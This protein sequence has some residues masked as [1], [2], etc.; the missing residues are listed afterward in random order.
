MIAI[1]NFGNPQ[2]AWTNKAIQCT[3]IIKN[4]TC[5]VQKNKTKMSLRLRR[6]QTK[7]GFGLFGCPKIAHNFSEQWNSE[8]EITNF[9][10]SEAGYSCSRY[11][12]L[13][14]CPFAQSP[15]SFLESTCG[16]SNDNQSESDSIYV[17][18]YKPFPCNDM[19]SFKLWM[20]FIKLL[21]SAD[22]DHY[23]LAL[24]TFFFFADSF[25]PQFAYI[26]VLCL[27]LNKLNSRFH[28]FRFVGLK[29]M[30]TENVD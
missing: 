23:L 9:L 3:M 27:S 28:L 17:F 2:S 29:F 22:D 21:F 7:N 10:L 11:C 25:T 15:V 1:G 30:G 5:K 12:C 26:F 6:K 20:G 16:Y 14:L 4:W 24:E 8:D 13:N 19:E 18:A